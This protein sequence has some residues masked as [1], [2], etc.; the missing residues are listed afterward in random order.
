MPVVEV[1]A[2]RR[3]RH[4]GGAANA[5]DRD[6]VIVI[7]DPSIVQPEEA[8]IL[9]AGGASQ[10]WRR[11]RARSK[12]PSAP[13]ARSSAA[14]RRIWNRAANRRVYRSCASAWR[15]SVPMAH[16]NGRGKT[17]RAPELTLT[18]TSS[19]AVRRAPPMTVGVA[20]GDFGEML[21]SLRHPGVGRACR[22]QFDAEN[23]V[24][25]HGAR[26]GIASGRRGSARNSP[27]R[28]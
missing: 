26:H 12:S 20:Q 1:D 16:Y 23:V 6:R 4:T 9:P 15:Q 25:R 18:R 13:R 14:G 17:C 8:Q 27:R 19:I 24:A 2:L 5:L 3:G 22:I 11:Q 10:R 7:L 28:T 21:P